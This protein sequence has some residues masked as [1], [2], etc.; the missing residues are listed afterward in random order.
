MPTIPSDIQIRRARD[1]DIPEMARLHYASF[2]EM[3]ITP[4]ERAERFRSNPLLSLEDH[5]VCERAGKLLG[6]FALYDF[7]LFRYK[8]LIRTGGIA[9]VSVAPEVR[10]Q[11]IALYMMIRAIQIMDQNGVALS[12]LYPFNHTFYRRLGWGFIGHIHY[13]RFPA[14]ALPVLPERDNVIY[15]WSNEERE[16]VMLCYRRF[17]EL[18]NGLFQRP[19]PV[20]FE[21]VF[22]RSF[23]YAYRSPDN[24]ELEGYITLNYEALPKEEYLSGCDIRVIDFVWLTD[25]ALRGLIGFLAAQSDQARCVILADQSGIPFEF[26]CENPLMQAGRHTWQMGAET[27][28]LGVSMMGRIVSLRRTL[29]GSSFGNG[30]GQIKLEIKDS[31]NPTNCEPL[32][33]EFKDGKAEFIKQNASLTLK[34]DISTFSS[35]YWGALSIEAAVSLGLVEIEGKADWRFLK[36]VLYIPKPICYEYF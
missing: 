27:A 14:G 23:C 10:R 28:R 1:G 5:W 34:T 35:I 12:A 31:L 18:H 11:K 30:A 20:W 21:S 24:G 15:V 26:L 4:E 19:E 32:T 2:P 29:L 3:G 36:S 25:R 9:I 8:D 22:K 7:K 6:L 17:A 33:I 13:Y 16:E